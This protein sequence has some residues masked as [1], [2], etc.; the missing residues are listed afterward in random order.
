MSIG[1]MAGLYEA[2]GTMI[3]GLILISIWT[4]I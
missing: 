1:M 4:L 2:P 3:L